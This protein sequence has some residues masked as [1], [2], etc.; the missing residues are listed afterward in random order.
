MFPDD[1]R[2]IYDMLQT[3]PEKENGLINR[4]N[5]MRYEEYKEWLVQKQLE[6]QQT[7]IKDGWKV[8]STTYWLYV[9]GVP[10]DFG[11]VRN[12]LTETLKEAGGNI[13]YG[14]APLYRGKGYGKELLH[15]LLLKVREAG[16]EK[17]LLTIHTDNLPVR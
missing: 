8:L 17:A 7:G 12:F 10:V 13:G 6:S 1:G 11:N 3:M 14:I 4:V 9:N 2:D 15:L 5:G 16:M